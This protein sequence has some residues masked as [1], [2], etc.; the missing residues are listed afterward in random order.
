MAMNYKD[1]LASVPKEITSDALWNISAYRY[2]LFVADLAWH[3]VSKLVDDKRTRQLSD[4]LYRAVGSIG[5]NICEGYS[6][7]GGRD[8]AR[9]Y[10]YSLGSARESRGWY[11][12]G[13]HVL[14][15]KVASHRIH[16]LTEI[17]RLLLTMV[18]DQRAVELKEDSIEYRVDFKPSDRDFVISENKLDALLENAPLV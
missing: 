18:P 13:R 6:R 11:F 15:E 2:S 17:A 16:L 7:S 12:D 14:G 3:D 10:E 8:R 5:A 9:F 4:Q 1:W